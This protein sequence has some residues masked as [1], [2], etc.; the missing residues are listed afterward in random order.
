MAWQ[1][2]ETDFWVW[3]LPKSAKDPHETR[4]SVT[5]LFGYWIVL[6]RVV[7]EFTTDAGEMFE[8]WLGDTACKQIVANRQHGS[9]CLVI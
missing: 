2:S 3:K 4:N 8:I 5:S 6:V 1:G 7:T 9:E